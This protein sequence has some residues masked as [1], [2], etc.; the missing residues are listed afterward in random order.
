MRIAG[1]CDGHVVV[2]SSHGTLVNEMVGRFV[3]KP[4]CEGEGVKNAKNVA[5]LGMGDAAAWAAAGH[6]VLRIS[7]QPATLATA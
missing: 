2:C 1:H 6:Q 3:A 4:Q 7:A 5:D